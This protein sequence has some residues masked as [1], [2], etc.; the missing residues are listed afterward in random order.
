[1][2]YW[3][4]RKQKA[5]LAGTKVED[6]TK[7]KVEDF[8]GCIPLLLDKSIVNGEIDLDAPFLMDVG[9]SATMFESNIQDTCSEADL[10]K[11]D[12]FI[13]HTHLR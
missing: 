5:E 3:W 9:E 13:L 4:E 11:Y 12:V 7:F 6:D 10:R 2:K 8:T 1:M